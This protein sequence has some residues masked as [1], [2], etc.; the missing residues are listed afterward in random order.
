[1]GKA[2]KAQR[3]AQNNIIVDHSRSRRFSYSLDG[4]DLSFNLRVDVKK[5]MVNFR[6]LLVKA[7]EDI[8]EELSNLDQK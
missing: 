7:I 3:E 8:D 5:Y 4:S 2:T 6:K 1:M